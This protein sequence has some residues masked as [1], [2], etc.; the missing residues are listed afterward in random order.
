MDVI[1]PTTG[2]RHNELKECIITLTKQTIPVKIT[3][4]L[5]AVHANIRKKVLELCEEYK[6][7]LLDEP[8][9]HIQGSH[10]AVACNYGLK[11]TQEN[12]VGFVDDDVSLP[13]TWAETSLKY[14]E[15]EKVAGVTSGCTPYT[16]PFHKVQSFGSNAHSQSF[17]SLT[18][19][20]SIPGY[21]SIYLRKAIENVGNFSEDI[22]G[23]EDWELNYRLRGAGWKL[24][25]IPETPVEHRHN[26]TLKSFINQMFGYSW[27]RSR[28]L[29][30]KHI[31]TLKHALPSIGLFIF[32]FLLTNI[33]VFLLMLGM[34]TAGICLLTLHVG[35]KNINSFFKTVLTFMAM[36]VSWALGYI[37]GLIY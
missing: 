16:S 20:E 27:S 17:T 30:T 5:G 29:K 1:I 25:G 12:F 35:T 32:M 13:Y 2:K 24:Y 26:Y 36:H 14:F 37:K 9:K 21:N 33:N 22:G 10:R 34:Y 15:D 3:V 11:N 7:Q 4:V 19:V 18:E 6:C 28:L 8:Y 31:F 23:C